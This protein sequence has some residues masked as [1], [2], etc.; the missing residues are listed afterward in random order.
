[1]Q[2]SFC[3]KIIISRNGGFMRCLYKE[4]G[5][6]EEWLAGELSCPDG[7]IYTIRGDNDDILRICAWDVEI[8]ATEMSI[9]GFKKRTGF[10]IE[11]ISVKIKELKV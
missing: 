2:V 5:V 8:N 9:S 1:M 6:D 3:W 11:E 10:D 7:R 4:V